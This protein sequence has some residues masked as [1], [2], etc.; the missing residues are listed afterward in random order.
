MTLNKS[1]LVAEV[2]AF[3]AILL[4]V[5]WLS[6]LFTRTNNLWAILTYALIYL[7]VRAAL[8]ARNPTPPP[9]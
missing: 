6:T 4:A 7:V 9:R 8:V 5:E 2:A 3:L 1:R